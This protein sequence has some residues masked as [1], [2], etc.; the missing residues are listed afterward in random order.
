MR[1][2]CLPSSVRPLCERGGQG[3]A[4]SHRGP[5]ALARGLQPWSCEGHRGLSLTELAGPVDD[6]GPWLE[7]SV[8]GS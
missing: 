7:G 3:G 4:L 1:P 8:Q 5:G 2:I 6:A